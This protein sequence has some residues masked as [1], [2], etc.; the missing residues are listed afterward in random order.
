VVR[1]IGGVDINSWEL[2]FR[3]VIFRNRT[4]IASV[5]QEC[6]EPGTTIITDCLRGYVNLESLGYH[7]LTVNNNRNF[8]DP[9]SGAN[10]QSIENRWCV[11]KPKFRARFI[12][13]R[14]ELSLMVVEFVFKLKIKNVCFE[15]MIMNL[16]K[17]E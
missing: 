10:T 5:L 17:F 8:V 6:I 7:H 1:V 12:T 2:F 11:F 16:K 14:N 3:E 13:V 4:T 9:V 15:T